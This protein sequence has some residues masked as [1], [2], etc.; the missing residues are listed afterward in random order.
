MTLFSLLD[1]TIDCDSDPF[2]LSWLI[3]DNRQLLKNVIGGRCSNGKMVNE[4]YTY[5]YFNCT[6]VFNLKKNQLLFVFEKKYFVIG[7]FSL[8]QMI[9]E[10]AQ[11][12]IEFH[13]AHAPKSDPKPELD[14]IFLLL[15]CNV[16]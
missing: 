12:L 15:D 6:P 9:P 1:S 8:S 16:N 14:S 7:P 13:R 3:R 4:L 10:C 2:H 11:P 5:N